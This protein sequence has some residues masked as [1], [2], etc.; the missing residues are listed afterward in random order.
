MSQFRKH[1]AC[2]VVTL[3]LVACISLPTA[4]KFAHIFKTHHHVFCHAKHE[5]HLHI[6]DFDCHFYKFSLNGHFTLP[7]NHIVI[8]RYENPEVRPVTLYRRFNTLHN[9]YFSLRAPPTLIFS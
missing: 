2:K 5:T 1:I 4:V 8:L 3:L 6:Y 7:E 9:T